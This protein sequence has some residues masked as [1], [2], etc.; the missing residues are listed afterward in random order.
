MHPDPGRVTDAI[1]P[2][3]SWDAFERAEPDM[4]DKGKA[5]L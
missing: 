1:G 5:L 2:M 3:E 4:A